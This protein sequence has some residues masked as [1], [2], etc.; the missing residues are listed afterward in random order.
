MLLLTPAAL[1]RIDYGGE[2]DPSYLSIGWRLWLAPPLRLHS[3]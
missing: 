2:D 3:A 1:H